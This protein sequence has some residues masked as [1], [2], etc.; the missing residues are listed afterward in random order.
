[1]QRAVGDAL[2][3]ELGT[4][5]DADDDRTGAPQPRHGNGILR[6]D[7]VGEEPRALGDASAGDPDV[8]LDD[9]GHAGKSGPLS[10]RDPRAHL[11]RL[12]A[13]RCRVESA[14]RIE[15]RVALGDARNERFGDLDGI[16]RAGVHGGGDRACV[17]LDHG[18]ALRNATVA[19][20]ASA[21]S[22]A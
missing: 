18:G 9:D 16:K 13:R 19:S 5:A 12:A 20:S 22:T 8:V 14:E 7:V 17:E 15:R 6:G 1:M 10:G 3:G 11:L 21:A 4:I 2:A